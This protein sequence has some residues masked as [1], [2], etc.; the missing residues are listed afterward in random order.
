MPCGKNPRGNL[1]AV[2]I[3]KLQHVNSYCRCY[4]CTK[5]AISKSAIY[6]QYHFIVVDLS[7]EMPQIGSRI[8]LFTF[9]HIPLWNSQRQFQ[10]KIRTIWCGFAN[11][12]LLVYVKASL[13]LCRNG[14]FSSWKSTFHLNEKKGVIPDIAY[15]RERRCFWGD[16]KFRY[17]WSPQ[18]KRP[19]YY[20]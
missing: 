13:R 10:T 3:W 12:D 1:P 16:T 6:P 8:G 4:P 5:V 14:L 19:L 2:R 11:V 15:R 18:V 17:W 9:L 20:S 7:S